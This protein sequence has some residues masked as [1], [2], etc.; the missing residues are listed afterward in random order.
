MQDA[1][2]VAQNRVIAVRDLTQTLNLPDNLRLF[3]L[4]RQARLGDDLNPVKAMASDAAGRSPG[5]KSL[6]C[7]TTLGLVPSY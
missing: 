2:D 1:P 5:L 4:H 7:L 3:L 6:A